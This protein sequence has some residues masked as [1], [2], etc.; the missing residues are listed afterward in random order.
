[1]TN[2]DQIG[3]VLMEAVSISPKRPKETALQN[4]ARVEYG[5]NRQYAEYELL[6]GRIPKAK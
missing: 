4:W 6:N 2:I 5:K 3:R 1:M